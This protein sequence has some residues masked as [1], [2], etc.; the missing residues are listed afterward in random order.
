MNLTYLLELEV[1]QYVQ[2][3]W[4]ANQSFL[5]FNKLWKCVRFYY[6]FS[7]QCTLKEN[8]NKDTIY[9]YSD[10]QSCC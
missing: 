1:E 2:A 9:I 10:R 6:T 8:K 3:I 5:L 7:M 4:S